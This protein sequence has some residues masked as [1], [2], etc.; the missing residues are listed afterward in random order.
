[1]FPSDPEPQFPL[2]ITLVPVP[3]LESDHTQPNLADPVFPVRR[4][5][6]APCGSTFTR[7]FLRQTFYR[8]LEESNI[9]YPQYGKQVFTGFDIN[10]F[11]TRVI[12]NLLITF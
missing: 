1:L 12:N 4:G 5:V 3:A 10:I 2:R 11:S 7:L 9:L 6:L 8:S